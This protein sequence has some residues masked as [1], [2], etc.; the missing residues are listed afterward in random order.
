MKYELGISCRPNYLRPSIEGLH[1]KKVERDTMDEVTEYLESILNVDETLQLTG[2]Y[3]SYIERM[4]PD[5]DS[6]QVRDISCWP[7]MRFAVLEFQAEDG[8]TWTIDIAECQERLKDDYKE[9]KFTY[10]DVDE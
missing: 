3:W 2:K 5:P 4:H 8:F 9:P 10:V 7:K 1:M 6:L